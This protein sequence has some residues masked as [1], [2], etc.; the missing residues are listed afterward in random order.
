M[1][2]RRVLF[3]L[4][5]MVM[6]ACNG[7]GAEPC[8]SVMAA[9]SLSEVLPK[10][11]NA[12]R[13]EGGMAI[14][15]SF[16]STSRLAAQLKAGAPSDIFFSADISWMDEM[17]AAR[18]VLAGSRRDLLSNRLVV[19]LSDP[20][21]PLLG[22]ADLVKT[23][24]KIALAGENVPAGRYAR[25]AL[26][27]AGVWNELAPRVVWRDSVR[28]VLAW[29]ARGEVP[30]GVVYATD[31]LV[32]PRVK[33]G[34]VFSPGDHNPIVYPAAV[35]SRSQQPRRALEFLTFCQGPARDIFLSAGFVVLSPRA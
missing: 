27:H 23:R 2:R 6:S 28:T 22:P 7:Q 11:A 12:W 24:G 31:A 4:G 14:Q 1:E 19:V 25:Q 5:G 21:S 29:V 18:L 9:A 3:V 33:V 17:D 16:D 13:Q 15:F 8:L 34:Y 10:V 20:G 26:Q 35:L 32:E 30:M